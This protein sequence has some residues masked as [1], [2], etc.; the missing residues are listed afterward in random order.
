MTCEAAPLQYGRA[1][2]VFISC[3]GPMLVAGLALPI[4]PHRQLA[5]CHL[6]VKFDFLLSCLQ[7]LAPLLITRRCSKDASPASLF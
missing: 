7:Q 2:L 6:K 5:S 4:L 3:Q 1:R